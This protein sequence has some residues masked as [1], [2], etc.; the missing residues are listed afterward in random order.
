MNI[1]AKTILLERII[2]LFSPPR[3]FELRINVM[4]DGITAKL[5]ICI[6]EIASSYSGKIISIIIGATK[7]PSRVIKIE[8]VIAKIFIFVLD[9]PTES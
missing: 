3:I 6:A 8:D 5:I 1:P 7:I 2:L 9:S 4:V